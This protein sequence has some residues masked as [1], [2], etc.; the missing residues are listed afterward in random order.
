MSELPQALDHTNRFSDKLEF[1]VSAEVY[2]AQL[3]EAVKRVLQQMRAAHAHL[4]TSNNTGYEK[5]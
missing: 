4:Q 2:S 3:R 1:K 5:M